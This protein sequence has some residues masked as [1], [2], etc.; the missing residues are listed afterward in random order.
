MNE[1]INDT[2]MPEG[3][4]RPSRRTM[5][6]AAAW[7]VPV[8]AVSQAVASPAMAQI[9]ETPSSPIIIDFGASTAC[10]IP[11]ENWNRLCYTKGYVLWAKFI[12]TL[13]VDVAVSV[14]AMVVGG[15]SQ[16]I[17][18]TSIPLSPAGCSGLFS[19]VYL[20][21]NSNETTVGIFSNAA[22]D[23]ANTDVIVNITYTPVGGFPKL[24]QLGGNITSPIGP[25]SQGVG[26]CTFPP[27]CDDKFN[28]PPSACD[29][30]NV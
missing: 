23:S 21:A 27:G 28:D 25:W 8:V 30:C 6:K 14:D 11:G 29:S 9:I 19:P 18:G 12:N 1:N 3:G 4:Y 20:P 17:V 2:N 24:V 16:C 7:S 22:T 10:K 15:V 5:L 13:N 26:S